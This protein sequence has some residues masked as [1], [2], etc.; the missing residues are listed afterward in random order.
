MASLAA[1]LG[2]DT[3]LALT[4]LRLYDNPAITDDGVEVLAQGLGAAST[5][6][7]AELDLSY[8]C[9]GDKGMTVLAEL[10]DT[11]R[12]VDLEVLS[13]NG[14]WDITDAGACALA[15]A[16]DEGGPTTAPASIQGGKTLPCH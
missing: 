5:T 16:I 11:S 3:F 13:L 10:M 1:L 9:L 4:T 15:R 14:N 2:Q 12:L 7:L 8:V 6:R